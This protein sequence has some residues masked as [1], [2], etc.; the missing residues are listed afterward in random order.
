[1][2]RIINS[3]GLDGWGGGVDL[4][5]LI[6]NSLNSTERSLTNYELIL[7]KQD[8]FY[9]VY[10]FFYTVAKTIIS[11]VRTGKLSVARPPKLELQEL[12]SIFG[13]I[14]CDLKFAELSSRGHQLENYATI[15]DAEIV[16]PLM[17]PPS[18]KF[19]LPWIGYLY[20]AQ[21]CRM[22]ELFTYSQIAKRD[23]QFKCML[24]KASHVIVNSR[25]A[26]NDLKLYYS[27][28]TSKICPLPFAPSLPKKLIVDELDVTSRYGIDDQQMYFITCNQ[29]WKHKNHSMLFRAFAE[30]NNMNDFKY[31]LICTGATNDIRFP[32]YF[33]ELKELIHILG[34]TNYICIL[35]R[36]P[37]RHQLSLLRNSIGLIQPT[38]F[39]G[40]PGGGAAYDAVA[41]GIPVLLSAI[42]VNREVQSDTELLYFDPYSQDQ[43]INC[44]NKLIVQKDKQRPSRQQLISTSKYNLS[45]LGLFMQSIILDC[46]RK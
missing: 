37:K 40:G 23:R 14:S 3:C 17:H 6:V 30:F 20:D 27:P 11:L 34:A 1:M 9:S 33:Q 45:K 46:V 35:G 8:S 22:P 10:S 15:L 42:P 43:L 31:K 19:T 25:A 26:M 39:E 2:V 32:R 24:N 12:K 28:F 18:D 4:L 13:N 16:F 41:L 5:A 21:H 44:L 29:F 38:L 36:I 7:E